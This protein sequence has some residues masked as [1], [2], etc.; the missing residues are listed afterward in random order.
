[1]RLGMCLVA[2]GVM[3]AMVRGW[4]PPF[5]YRSN[6]TPLRGVVSR[7]DFKQVDQIK[8]INDRKMPNAKS[9]RSLSII[10]PP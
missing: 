5:G 7:V 9:H 3:I 2:A 4:E 6:Y 10:R 1:M 8:T